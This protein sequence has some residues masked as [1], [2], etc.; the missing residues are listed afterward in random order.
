[1]PVKIKR[2]RTQ[3]LDFDLEMRLVEGW[4]LDSAALWDVDFEFRKRCW[5]RYR[6]ALVARWG[7]VTKL[8]GWYE[9]EANEE[10]RAA[11]RMDECPSPGFAVRDG[12]G[13]LSTPENLSVQARMKRPELE[14]VR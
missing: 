4:N 8:Y 14:V 12:I 3:R 13:T 1:M 6:D 2:L 11:F 9:F 7:D 10:Q 5:L